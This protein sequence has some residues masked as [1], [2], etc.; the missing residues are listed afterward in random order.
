MTLDSSKIF[1]KFLLLI[2]IFLYLP[3]IISICINKILGKKNIVWYV[4]EEGLIPFIKPIHDLLIRNEKISHYYLIYHWRKHRYNKNIF[5]SNRFIPYELFHKYIFIDAFISPTVNTLAPRFAT[6]I[7]V[8]HGVTVKYACLDKNS[9]AKFKYHFVI[10]QLHYEQTMHTIKEHQ[11]DPDKCIVKKVGYPKTDNIFNNPIN[12]EEFLLALNLN[13]K[14]KTIVYAPS[15]EENLS[16]R[17]Y[18]YRVVEEMLRVENVNVILKLHPIHMN[19]TVDDPKF[20]KATGGIE[21]GKLFASRFSGDK[22]FHLY[23][24]DDI[25]P[26]LAVSD[27]LISDFS[28]AT[29]EFLALNKPL[30]IIDCPDFFHIAPLLY[31]TKKHGSFDADYL[32]NNPLVN[33]GRHLAYINKNLESLSSDIAFLL[34]HP[35][36]KEKE[37]RQFAKKLKYNSG[38]ASQAAVKAICD[39]L[40]IE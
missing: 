13:P 10:N 12:K 39:I 40:S 2:K 36:F 18:G 38:H 32:K 24:E 17:R 34:E 22:R 29:L 27:L 30:L 4:A 33:G 5:P 28:G 9:F 16:I 8:P 35:D 14:S 37:R 6:N 7:H 15:H 19:F 23:Q 25:S 11:L 3:G 31:D 20:Y 21:W 1:Y 26:L